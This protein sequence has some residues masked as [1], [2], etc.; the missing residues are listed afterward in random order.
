MKTGS[1]ASPYT[2]LAFIGNHRNPI[3]V[4]RQRFCSLAFKD[5]NATFSGLVN[6]I[7]VEFKPDKNHSLWFSSDMDYPVSI[8]EMYF[9]N[10]VMRNTKRE[11]ESQF[12]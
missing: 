4:E 6:H 3:L 11:F 2:I 1:F 5:G 12:L 9:F 10:S 8:D 7:M